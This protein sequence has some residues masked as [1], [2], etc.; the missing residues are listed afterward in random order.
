MKDFILNSIKLEKK[1]TSHLFWVFVQT[2][3]TVNCNITSKISSMA[4][5]NTLI[6]AK[7][8]KPFV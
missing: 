8:P 3:I 5:M 4:S 6:N 2:A 7:Y 1:K